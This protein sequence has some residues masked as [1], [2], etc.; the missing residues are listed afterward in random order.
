[1]QELG[2]RRGEMLDMTNNGAGLVR[3][4]YI[5]PTRGLLGL[6]SVLLNSTRGTGIMARQF[7]RY[8][9]WRGS[10]AERTRG[11]LVSMENGKATGFAINNLQERGT[12]FIS[13]TVECYEGMVVG[14]NARPDDM[15]VNIIRE[16]KLSNMRASGSDEN[17]MLTPPRILSLEQA[18]EYIADDELV[19]VTPQ[20][21]RLR[22]RYLT[23][24]DRDRAKKREAALS[25]P[26]Q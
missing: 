7:E 15:T 11:V 9:S 6:R 2:E 17:I 3:L 8:D 23:K 16:K 21:I 20:T 22:K 18:M 12:L 25:A 19:E 26:A 10:I 5:V 4:L 1:M 24:E 14:E 13:P